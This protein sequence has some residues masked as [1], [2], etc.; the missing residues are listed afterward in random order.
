LAIL[1]I[2]A[3]GEGASLRPP[4]AAVEVFNISFVAAPAQLLRIAD[5]ILKK[6][7]KTTKALRRDIRAVAKA[8]IDEA[9]ERSRAVREIQTNAPVVQIQSLSPPEVVEKA[10][11]LRN[12]PLANKELQEMVRKVADSYV[13]IAEKNQQLFDEFKQKYRDKLPRAE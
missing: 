5:E 10:K 1:D 7:M 2:Q 11:R 4:N 13:I 6:Q 3:T 9:D 8:Y 12:V